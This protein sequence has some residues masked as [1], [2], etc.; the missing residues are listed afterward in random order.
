MRVHDA[1]DG[2]DRAGLAL[3]PDHDP[4]LPPG[5]V[6]AVD[7]PLGEPTAVGRGLHAPTIQSGRGPARRRVQKPVLLPLRTELEGGPGR[8]VHHP[9]AP[10]RTPAGGHSRGSLRPEPAHQAAAAAPARAAGGREGA[11][12]AGHRRGARNARDALI[13][14]RDDG[15]RGRDVPRREPVRLEDDDVVVALPAGRLACHDLLELVYLEPVEYPGL[16]RLDQVGRLEPRVLD[17]VAADEAR[18]LE[19]HVVELAAAA[20]VCTDR[21]HERTRPQPLAPKHGVR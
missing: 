19:Y 7:Y 18:A 4:L 16:D 14:T 10:P 20:V 13:G 9:G 11:R 15:G 12:R 5:I 1:P 17:R 21:A 8:R 6:D 2:P 3:D